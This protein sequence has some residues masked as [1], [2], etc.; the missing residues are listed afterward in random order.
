MKAII[1]Y[2]EAH[3]QSHVDQLVQ[4]LKFPSISADSAF[5]KDL[6]ACAEHIVNKMRKI[7]LDAEVI[8]TEGH[9][10]VYGEYIRPENKH[11]L[12]LYGHYDVQPVDPL[13]LWDHPPF[14]PYIEG[15]TLYAR[16][17]CDDK[18]QFLTHLLAAE[19]FL[20]IRGKLPVN[21]KFII[22][23]EEETTSDHLAPYI[24][25]NKEKLKADG[26]VVSDTAMYTKELP[27]ITYGLR[28][29]AVAEIR[30]TGPS[31]DLHSGSFGGSVANPA[32]ELARIIASFHDENRHIAIH[33]F[34]E[35]VRDLEPWEREMFASLP[36]DEKEYLEATG[37]PA[38]SGESGFSTL[39]QRWGRPTCDV[40]GIFGGYQGEGGKTIIP[41][42]AGC[43]VSMRL[44]PDQDP[45][46]L[47]KKFKRHVMK[48]ASPGVTVSVECGGGAKPAIV[49]RDSRLVQAGSRALEK[50]FG[51]KPVFIREGGSIPIVNVFKE[52]LGLDTLL[53]GFGQYDNNV[54]SPNE[55]FSLGDYHK[56]IIAMAYLF[57]EWGR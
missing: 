26:V 9:P 45:D 38:V 8:P 1:E 50:S 47:L 52:E 48:M 14:E 3:R 18:G 37:S 7:G 31:K 57:D 2:M 55:N 5:S 21:V 24:I 44:V 32:N 25:A 20:K 42:W 51:V 30:V 28:G 56:G 19:A 53:L 36:F 15:D 39:E 12:L 22:E 11:T 17:A 13:D 29:I 27:A 33:G 41:S 16:G 23:G 46:D 6:V 4:L 43:K 35:H 34:Y 54:H 10:L 40:N 49:S